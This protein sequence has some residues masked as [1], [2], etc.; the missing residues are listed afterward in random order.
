MEFFMNDAQKLQVTS[1][2][3]KLFPNYNQHLHM[4]LSIN[5][6]DL[7]KTQLKAI[8]IIANEQTMSMSEL[9][10]HMCISREQA[11]RVINPLADRGL[12]HREIHPGNRR[13]IDIRLST[14]GITCL[15]DMKA[16]YSEPL[17]SSLDRL[18]PEELQKFLDAVDVVIHTLGK[19]LSTAE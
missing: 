5:N 13:Q 4:L 12:I 2:L 6:L 9:A 10:D 18:E 7:T 15:E 3:M 16:T 19:L 1:S 17:F 11:T 8:L 14:Q